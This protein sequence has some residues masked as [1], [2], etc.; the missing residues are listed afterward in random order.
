[1]HRTIAFLAISFLALPF[2]AFAQ[3]PSGPYVS[4]AAGFNKM[5]QEDVDAHLD[6]SSAGVTPGELLTA[7]GPALVGSFGLGLGSAVRVEVEGSYLSNKITSETGLAGENNATGTEKK[8]GV[9]GNAFYE[10]GSGGIRPY[11]GAGAGMQWVHEPAA[12]A[13]SGGITVTAEAQ[14]KSSFA[15][16]AIAGVAFPVRSVHGLSISA[17]YRYLALAGTRTY[18]ATVT[19]PG[20]GSSR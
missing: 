15:Y 4:F 10:F 17:E 3:N 8:T 2:S 9:M 20:V 18:T 7:V 14:T 12:S 19:V 16:Q 11:L 13:S 1:M 5:Q 6:G